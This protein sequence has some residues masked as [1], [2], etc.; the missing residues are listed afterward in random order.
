MSKSKCP[1]CGAVSLRPGA[2]KCPACQAWVQPPRF[3]KRRLRLSPLGVV[4]F[5][6]TLCIVGMI[7]GVVAAVTVQGRRPPSRTVVDA[8]NDDQSAGVSTAGS[9][10]ASASSSA[11]ASPESPT[12]RGVVDPPAA[13]GKFVKTEQ[14][15]LDAPPADIL[16]SSDA[17]YFFVLAEDGTLRAHDA[18]TG[19]EKRRVKLPG[20]GKA[21]KSLGGGRTAILGLPADLVVIDEARWAAGAAETDFLKRVAMRDVVDLVVVGEPERIVLVTGQGGR[22][23]RLS[24]DFATIETEFV[25]VP[26]V[27][28]LATMRVGGVERLVMLSALR[29]PADS[30][31]VVTCDPTSAS[32]GASRGVWS[33]VADPRVSQRVGSDKLLLFDALAATVI[34]FSLGGERRIAPSGPQP[35]AAFRWVG[36]RA[37]VIGAAGQATVVSLA[38]REVQSTLAL[39][40]IPSAT[41]GTMDRRV[42]I[43][44]LGGGLRGRG[45]KTVVLAGEPLAVES[46]IETG[47]G[48][49]L[50]AIAPKDSA[51]VVGATIGRTVSLLVRK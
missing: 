6:V 45:S 40:G 2:T 50:L 27:Q 22:V 17:A 20:K 43:A 7:S 46:T 1:S 24:N 25:A 47:E 18:T 32:F 12:S 15:R 19:A 51:A 28:A 31:A 21:L 33:A 34:D 9:S 30:G 36:D 41:V 13:E 11:T 8:S 23:Q 42:V 29:P 49:H 39:G 4:G 26:P 3:A 35:I 5:S 44:A 38:R 10:A 16:Y 14:V 48:S 37:V